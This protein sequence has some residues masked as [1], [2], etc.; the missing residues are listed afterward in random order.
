MSTPVALLPT[1]G[2]AL[3]A[4]AAVVAGTS[5]SR[6][7]A[8]GRLAQVSTAAPVWSPVAVWHRAARHAQSSTRAAV[9][10]A[11]VAGGATGLLLAGPV[12]AMLLAAYGCLALR[13]LLRRRVRRTAETQRTA[14]LDAVTGLA[15][16]LRAGLVPSVALSRAWPQLMG[17]VGSV[18]GA[19]RGMA[20]APDRPVSLLRSEAGPA[21]APITAR[22]ATAWQLAADTGAPLADVLDRLDVE[23]TDQERIRRRAVAQTAGSR[24]TSVLLA[25]LPLAG[26]G[27]G[28]SIGAHPLR[29]LL[30]TPVGAVCAV[31]TV[32]LQV[33]G[34]LW[35][36]RLS[37][38]DESGTHV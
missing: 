19:A 25:L 34:L 9:V 22:L 21:R 17:S 6:Q 29:V 20:V 10:L 18:D 32:A 36:E 23:L 13:L 1:V 4:A 11:A 26:I 16:D 35:S 15:D 2:A 33:A 38:L 24:A 31:V 27:L 37:R 3:L 12:S 7:T 14:A 5:R 8:K 28:Y 30:H